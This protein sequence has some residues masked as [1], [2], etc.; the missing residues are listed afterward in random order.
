MV[1]IRR[2][3]GA[4]GRISASNPQEREKLS[5]REIEINPRKGYLFA[6]L[7]NQELQIIYHVRTPSPQA[8]RPLR[9]TL[10]PLIRNHYDEQMG[11]GKERPGS[12]LQKDPESYQ[13]L[14]GQRVTLLTT[15]I[16]TTSSLYSPES[17][18]QKYKR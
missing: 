8:A 14:M 16:P 6:R 3:R 17:V 9:W 7:P 2:V 5:S 18:R 10:R 11:L 4:R 1:E 12:K 15:V 13:K